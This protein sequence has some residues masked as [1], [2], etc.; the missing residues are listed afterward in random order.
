VKDQRK[1]DVASGTPPIRNALAFA[2]S[3]PLGTDRLEAEIKALLI[4][5]ASDWFTDP[6]TREPGHVWRRIN[7]LEAVESANSWSELVRKA[8]T[9]DQDADAVLCCKAGLMIERGERLEGALA[10]YIASR[11]CD[12]LNVRKVKKGR[13]GDANVRRDMFIVSYVSMLQQHGFSPTRNS[14]SRDKSANE[15]GC[16]LLT[17]VLNAVGFN[18]SERGVEEVWN[19]RERR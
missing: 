3:P 16:S 9:G 12:L 15:S 19:N 2:A 14:E 13:D 4:S 6:N 8:E 18:I 17:H 7:L 11:L 1:S 10:E 5:D